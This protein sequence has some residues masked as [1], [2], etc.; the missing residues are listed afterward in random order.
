MRDELL[1]GAADTSGHIP[2]AEVCGIRPP[3]TRAEVLRVARINSRVT[4]WRWIKAGIF[5][6]PI[7]DETRSH[8]WRH[9]DVQAWANGQRARAHAQA[10]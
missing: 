10:A 6:A 4:L 2:G 8:L 7:E 1:S 3:L 9:A 5:P